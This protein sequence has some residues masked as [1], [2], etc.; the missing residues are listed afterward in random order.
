MCDSKG[1]IRSDRDDLNSQKRM[2]ATNIDVFTLE[3]AM[4]GGHDYRNYHTNCFHESKI[5]LFYS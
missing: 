4:N 2:F 1:V 5:L 3:E